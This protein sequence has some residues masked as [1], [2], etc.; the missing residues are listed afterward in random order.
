MF[1]HWAANYLFFVE[2]FSAD[3]SKLHSTCPKKQVTIL[4]PKK[5]CFKTNFR[6]WVEI[7]SL[8]AKVFFRKNCQNC[9]LSLHGNILMEIISFDLRVFDSISNAEKEDQSS[10]LGRL[11]KTAFYVSKEN[12]WGEKK[13]FFECFE[14][15]EKTFRPLARKLLGKV[16]KTAIYVPKGTSWRDLVLIKFCLFFNF[17]YWAKRS[18]PACKIVSE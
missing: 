5:P 16:V 8:L 3:F 10:V 7:C 9:I 6:Q 14:T 15:L 13:Q 17:G 4:F 1:G 12:L 2:K 18:R 11:V